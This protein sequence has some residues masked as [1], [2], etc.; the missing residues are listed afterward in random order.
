MKLGLIGYPIKHSLSPWIHQ[1]FLQQIDRKGTYLLYDTKREQFQETIEKIKEDKLDGFNITVP[2]KQTIMKYLDELDP[3]AA[4]IGAVNTV[5]IQNGKWIG[6]NTDGRGYLAAIESQFP[7]LLNGGQ[8][9][10]ILGSGGAARGIF[11]ALCNASF[12]TVDIANRTLSKATDL[13]PLNL[14]DK[15]NSRALSFQEAEQSVQDYNLIIQ[16]T[17]VG[18]KPTVKEQIISLQHV[19]KDA[20]VSDIVYQ[21]LMTQFLL[22]ADQMG[23]SIHQGHTMLLYQAKLAFQLWSDREVTIEPL[24]AGLEDILKGNE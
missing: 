7:M 1:Q 21:P 9:V 15:V 14:T 10:L 3:Y 22:E 11:Y 20:V 24:L 12:H 13:L 6:Y 23:A 2:F 17:S 19:K 5:V 18:M 4:K 16:T 8:R